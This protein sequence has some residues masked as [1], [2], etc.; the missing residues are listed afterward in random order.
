MHFYILELEPIGDVPCWYVGITNKPAPMDR[1]REHEQGIG[2]KWTQL[3]PPVRLVKLEPIPA[4]HKDRPLAFE[5]ELTLVM[6]KKRGARYVRG[7]RW[8]CVYDPNIET[9]PTAAGFR[10]YVDR[11]LSA[12]AS[13]AVS[14]FP[15]TTPDYQWP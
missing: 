11:R 4:R 8:C 5:D 3:H 12:Q 6:M 15:D 1:I 7:G 14:R 13:D 9:G 10:D 2:A